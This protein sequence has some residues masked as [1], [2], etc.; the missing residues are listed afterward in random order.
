MQNII[1]LNV[2]G[3]SFLTTYTTLNRGFFAGLRKQNLNNYFIDRDPTHFRHIINY[4]RGTSTFP[5]QSEEL[6]ELAMEANFYC[7]HELEVETLR[8]IP[9]SSNN[10]INYFLSK[11]VEKLQ[12]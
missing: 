8:R 6:R 11:I 3:I 5:S 2:G 12:R 9:Y 10:N 4:L 1:T 7:L